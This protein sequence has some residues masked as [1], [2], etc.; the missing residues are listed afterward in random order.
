MKYPIIVLK[1]SL[2]L[3]MSSNLYCQIDSLRNITEYGFYDKQRIHYD[4][5]ALKDTIKLFLEDTSFY[6]INK[7]ILYQNEI[8]YL[9]Y[10]NSSIGLDYVLKDSLPDGFYCL[11]NLTKK[12]ARRIHEKNN[13]IVASGEFKNKMKQGPFCFYF[14]PENSKWAS[15]KKVIYFED[16]IINGP[17]IEFER[18]NIMY[19]GEY[20][21]GV[22]N[23]F[24][25]FYNGGAPAI[26]LYENGVKVK[27]SYFW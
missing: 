13:Y 4:T 22:K 26:I 9:N 5:I 10:F 1:F 6:L 19:L 16:D 17:I 23:G 27:D 2:L 14:M 12:Q 15:A 20:K 11:Y 18:D 25:Y 7:N 8:E 24:F 21:M 3:L